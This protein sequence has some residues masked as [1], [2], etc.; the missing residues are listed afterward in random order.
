[1]SV[2]VSSIVN[3]L[4]R[5]NS[6]HIEVCCS[7]E[8]THPLILNN[9]NKCG[10]GK[11]CS[12]GFDLP[13]NCVNSCLYLLGCVSADVCRNHVLQH[14][15][16][17]T[18]EW[19]FICLFVVVFVVGLCGN[20]LVC[21]VVRRSHHMRTSVNIFIVNLALADFLVIL[22]CLPPTVLADAT[23]TW[24]LGE[25]MCKIVPFLQ[26]SHIINLSLMFIYI[27][28]NKISTNFNNY[29][30]THKAI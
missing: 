4:S 24:Y 9:S 21:Y 11:N 16:P 2:T 19:I 20:G 8:T 7:M 6:H 12:N 26:V 3:R 22:V 15:Y 27:H 23:E 25:T 14:V 10:T 5:I 30:M 13:Q 17:T 18:T 29:F 1:M 28:N